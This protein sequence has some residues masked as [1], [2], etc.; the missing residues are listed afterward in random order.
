MSTTPVWS[1]GS[2][3]PWSISKTLILPWPSP[4]LQ[5][6]ESEFVPLLA[7]DGLEPCQ[8]VIP[9]QKKTLPCSSYPS[10]CSYDRYPPMLQPAMAGPSSGLP[11][12][13]LKRKI[14]ARREAW[15]SLSAGK[16]LYES[17][18]LAGPKRTS[19]VPE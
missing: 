8:H 6:P 14:A 12:P 18:D 7:C 13:E 2:Q 11:V 4:H 3:L 9:L 10:I 17:K 5:N 16:E 1:E 19:A 15:L